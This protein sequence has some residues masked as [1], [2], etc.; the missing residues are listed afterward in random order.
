MNRPIN[1][2]LGT[3]EF[4][5]PAYF[6]HPSKKEIIKILNLA[7]RSGITTLDTAD[8]YDTEALEPIFAGF[9][10]LF[11]SRREKGSFYHYYLEEP[12]IKGVTRASVYTLEQC[13]GLKE[14]IVPF[15][16]NNT[17]FIDVKCTRL[18]I[19][20]VFDRGRL[21]NKYTVK[22]CLDFVKKKPNEGV[23]VGV[24]SIRELKEI[25][26]AL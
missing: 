26:N 25:I 11:K 21:L 12:R 20:S 13:K 10:Q 8:T 18:Y 14:V 17:T 22:E 6:P 24:R 7:W 2:I 19:R 16:I 5:H 23:I 3:A 4:G 9:K 15:N 1:L